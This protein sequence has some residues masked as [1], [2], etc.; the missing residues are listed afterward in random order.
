[1]QT[2]SRIVLR[3]MFFELAVVFAAGFIIGHYTNTRVPTTAELEELLKDVPDQVRVET[4]E[5]AKEPMVQYN[6][7]VLSLNITKG[8]RLFR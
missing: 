8:R 7:G 3:P 2:T 1:M 6:N 5:K 4:I